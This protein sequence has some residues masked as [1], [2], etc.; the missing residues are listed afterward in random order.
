MLTY[1]ET[2]A[3]LDGP[4]GDQ[5]RSLMDTYFQRNRNMTEKI[6]SSEGVDRALNEIDC[7]EKKKKS[8]FEKYTGIQSFVPRG[9]LDISYFDLFHALVECLKST[10]PFLEAPVLKQL[11]LEKSI[12]ESW[13]ALPSSKVH[14]GLSVR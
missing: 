8:I 9:Q 3:G 5:C 14:V 2:V 10:I 13:G 11:R 7:M 1:V 4:V 6:Q 12:A